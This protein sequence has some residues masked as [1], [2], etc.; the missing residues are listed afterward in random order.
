MCDNGVVLTHLE[1][2]SREK[3]IAASETAVFEQLWS[4]GVATDPFYNNERLNQ[5]KP[6]FI[7]EQ[8][9]EHV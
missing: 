9:V 6:M 8:N 3:S 4:E 1:S 2:A 5:T 7:F